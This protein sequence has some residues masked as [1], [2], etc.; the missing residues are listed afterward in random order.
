MPPSV[1]LDYNGLSMQFHPAV[2]S[3]FE[4]TFETPTAPQVQGWPLIQR[5]ENVLIAAPTG[6]GKTL[7][8]FLCAIDG[9]VREAAAGTLNNTT[10][11]LYISP[12]KALAND[13]QKNLLEPLQGIRK[14][15]R[16][17]GWECPEIRAWVR[18]GDTKASERQKAIRTPPHILVTTPESFYILLTS[19]SGRQMLESVR[20]VIVDEIHS[21]AQSK[22]GSHLTL[23]LERLRDLTGD[24]FQR[25]GLSA[26]QRPIE[27]I[28]GFLTGGA[29]SAK[30][31]DVGH[32][33]KLD[34]AVEVP[35]SELSAVASHQIW[36]EVC[37]R[38]VGLIEGHR[39]TLIFVN[40]R[41]LTER[42]AHQLSELLGEEAVAAHHD[43]L[44]REHRLEAERRLKDGELKVAVATASLELGIDVG[45]ID[46]VCQIGSPRSIVLTLQRVGRSGHWKG[47][48]PKGRLLATTIDELVECAALVTAIRQ[49]QLDRIRIPAL[50]LDILAQQVVAECSQRDLDTKELLQ[51]VRRAYP[52]RDLTEADLR[53]V[54]AVLSEGITTRHGRRGAHLHWDRINDIV[55]A[56]RS[57]RLA[58]ITSG[59]AIPDIAN[60]QVRADPED[61]VVGNL[62]EDFAVESSRG[63]I[64]LLGNTSWRI[65]RVESAVVRV[66]DAQGAPPTIPFWRGEAPGRT[67][68]LSDAVSEVREAVNRGT[69]TDSVTWLEKE[70]KLSRP[71]AEQAALYIRKGAQALGALPT[72][73]R[74]VAERFF[75]E[76]GGMQLVLHAPFGSRINKAWGYALRKRFCRSFNFELQ[77]AATE[78]GIVLSLSD[79][80]SFPLSTVFGYIRSHNA[81]E[82]LVQALLAVP[83]FGTRW[84]WVAN[85]SLAIL[86][87][88]G[89]RR[90]PSPLQR[91]RS[92][93]LLAAIFPEQAACLEHIVG[94]IEIPDH[95]L[96]RETLKECQ[97]DAMDVE[98][99][100]ATIRALEAGEIECHAIDTREPSP[101]SQEILNANPYAYLD[102]APLE[103]RRTRAVQSRR[104]LPEGEENL[105]QLDGDAI[106]EV[107]EEA[108]P[109]M[110]DR[111]EVHDALLTLLVMSGGELKSH[112][113]DLKSL[114]AQGRVVSFRQATAKSTLWSSAERFR[115]VQRIYPEMESAN[116]PGITDL[117]EAQWGN[118]S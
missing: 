105:A 71:G 85:R 81:R 56:R 52:Y 102:D 58:A 67:D 110:R 76:A 30:V 15:A 80:H 22:R 73:Q 11:V 84:R 98:G 107:A 55:R 9:L 72:K 100:E 14:E 94:D 42:L 35:E 10:S 23:S 47:A 45:T 78:N 96:I 50:P 33:R 109:M 53:E 93:D 40:T 5:G 43:S 95:P 112:V 54:L 69:T 70:C 59:G 20:H 88:Q 92:D 27:A 3:W 62:D 87:F 39:T 63:D 68:E 4:K 116:I 28:S 16:L 61:K 99:L 7:S 66:E 31:I 32:R 75:D 37:S 118:D 12:L 29:R 46:L 117:D 1:R 89:G 41:R 36:E 77:A 108:W 8:A 51:M 6:S 114:V 26:T 83:L 21:L 106:R 25:I 115:L 49:G 101:F 91:I 74:V 64:F 19:A 97:T 104:S 79:Q 113:D 60:F 2:S 34:L 86:R 111:E 44:S 24:E 48:I 103:E 17:Q 38:I 65:R 90:V 13:I 57:A 82:L 18:T